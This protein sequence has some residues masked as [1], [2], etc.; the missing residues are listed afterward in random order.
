MT[1][2]TQPPEHGDDEEPEHDMNELIRRTAGVGNRYLKWDDG[3]IRHSND[4][5]TDSPPDAA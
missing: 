5:I 1:E 2:P 4:P 3:T